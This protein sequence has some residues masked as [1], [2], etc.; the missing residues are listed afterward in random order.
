MKRH[1]HNNDHNDNNNNKNQTT[2]TLKTYTNLII[3][4]IITFIT[5][6]I[7]NFFLFGPLRNIDH[8]VNNK[9]TTTTNIVNTAAADNSD[10]KIEFLHI[11][12]QTFIDTFHYLNNNFKKDTNL[13]LPFPPQHNESFTQKQIFAYQFI[14][15]YIL[16][17][18]IL[19]CVGNYNNKH[20]MVN[21]IT[22]QLYSIASCIATIGRLS[23]ESKLFTKNNNKNGNNNSNNNG[24]NLNKN[25]T[26]VS[27]IPLRL[28]LEPEMCFKGPPGMLKC[29]DHFSLSN[30]YKIKK[31]NQFISNKENWKDFINIPKLKNFNSSSLQ[32]NVTT[33]TQLFPKEWKNKKIKVLTKI[34]FLEDFD[35]KNY[36]FDLL[37]SRKETMK[38]FGGLIFISK[39]EYLQLFCVRDLMIESLLKWS[40]MEIDNLNKNLNKNLEEEELFKLWQILFEKKEI[41]LQ[42]TLQNILQKLLQRKNCQSF[43]QQESQH[44]NFEKYYI[45]RR[46]SPYNFTLDLKAK[47][48]FT[49][50]K[51]YTDISLN[52]LKENYKYEDILIWKWNLQ[53]KINNIGFLFND[54]IPLQP[55]EWKFYIDILDHL[56]PVPEI[57]NRVDKIFKDLRVS[58]DHIVVIHVQLPK[59]NE[60]FYRGCA[61]VP[62][63]FDNLISSQKVAH[64]SWID[65]F[66]NQLR[67]P[68]KTAVIL[69][70]YGFHFRD[71][72][73][74]PEEE[75]YEKFHP[76]KGAPS[77]IVE[78]CGIY[79]K[80]QNLQNWKRN[81]SETPK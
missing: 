66:V 13:L 33:V 77:F 56:K 23:G 80:E 45:D 17:T 6:F 1:F 70:G 64:A 74:F 38:D 47:T 50:T 21:G 34:P 49:I 19:T 58:N 62:S 4:F 52:K 8:I 65:L 60:G 40:K 30:L 10:V 55:N 46:I 72:S 27:G 15:H 39:E 3:L 25:G 43:I 79:T 48:W 41:N 37:I 51:H 20:T 26:P 76:G 24:N 81:R 44:L 31:I 36:E 53:K 35:F 29:D 71:A 42:N 18:Q 69:I 2:T 11:F 12:Q 57:E 61:R 67:L 9:A 63:L 5:F 75:L 22:N 78:K 54:W 14:D 16:H 7:L 59:H 32:W 68:P 73:L 28:I